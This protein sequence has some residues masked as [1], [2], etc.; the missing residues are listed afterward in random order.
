MT[1]QIG[2]FEVLQKLGE[3]A[4]GEVFLARDPVIGR[5]VALK[6]IRLSSFSGAEARE[7]FFLEAQA[8]GRLNHPNLVTIHEFGEDQGLLYLAMEYVPGEDLAALI[9]DR[10]LSSAEVLEVLAQ[11][12]DGLG[13]AHQQ[14]VLHRDIKPSNIRVS[15]VS[16]RLLAKVLDF[17]IAKVVGS[18][19]TG[20]G[21]LLGTFGYM[22]P[23]YIKTGKPDPRSDLFAVGVM[24]YEALTGTR[25]FEGDTTATILYR[26]LHE[27]P[28][29]LEPGALNGISPEVQNILNRTLAK[30]LKTRFPSADLLAA[31]LRA[32][33]DPAWRVGSRA[34]GSAAAQAPTVV[35]R[36]PVRSR[37]LLLAGLSTLLAALGIIGFLR[38]RGRAKSAALAATPI[39]TAQVPDPA[40][41]PLAP[42]EPT[43]PTPPAKPEPK[44]VEKAPKAVRVKPAEPR[45]QTLDQASAALDTDPKAA[46]RYL[47][48]Y[49][50]KDP[51]SER[52][53]ALRVVAL[54]DLG[55]YQESLD[56]LKGAGRQGFR[57]GMML[58]KFPRLRSMMESESKERRLPKRRKG[59]EGQE[60]E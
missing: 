37:W 24:L 53:Q 1:L 21:Q 18:E 27:E 58:R 31:A 34:E 8:A 10:S 43:V 35:T 36:V 22:A 28:K 47:N 25:P 60:Q 2:K 7:R 55:R 17:G 20:T 4:M 14:G 40:P 29:A 11:V 26:V 51:T 56:A 9:R 39:P 33:R 32:A 38:W 54:Y 44:P 13:Y 16:R 45:I 50:K 12:C 52:A 41:V 30:D 48:E 59:K 49:L 6:T 15:R 57:L 23:E 3:G 19:M 5:E 42:V 46:L